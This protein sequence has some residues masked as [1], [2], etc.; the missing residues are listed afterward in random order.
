MLGQTM[1]GEGWWEGS[2]RK[3]MG[4]ARD[5]KLACIRPCARESSPHPRPL[6]LPDC[7][8]RL[9]PRLAGESRDASCLLSAASP[10]IH[11]SNKVSVYQPNGCTCRRS[12]AHRVASIIII[13]S[14]L[15]QHTSSCLSR[16][17][18]ASRAT[19]T[20]RAV[21]GLLSA[22]SSAKPILTRICTSLEHET[23]SAFRIIVQ[24]VDTAYPFPF[25]S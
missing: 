21:I 20:T 10:I 22:F 6:R 11:P 7:C 17:R 5:S 18:A 13:A 19:S 1:Q 15:Q 9:L 24:L 12:T 4:R 16:R 8:L 3:T 2:R 23:R 14:Y 25:S